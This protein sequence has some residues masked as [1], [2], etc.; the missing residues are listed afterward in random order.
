MTLELPPLP[1]SVPAGQCPPWDLGKVRRRPCPVC[2]RDSPEPIV[3]RPD[4]LVVHKCAECGMI[5]LA[6]VPCQD[7]IDRLYRGYGAFK[8]L[9]PPPESGSRQRRESAARYGHLTSIL[10][11]TGGLRGLSVCEIGCSYG[12][13]LRL[14]RHMGARTHGVEL[15]AEA[16]RFVGDGGISVAERLEGTEQHDVVCMFQV[17]EHLVRPAEMI[18]AVAKAVVADGRVLTAVPNGGEYAKAGPTWIGFRVDLEHLNYFDLQSLSRLLQRHGLLVERF[19][20]H[21]QPSV[22]RSA[23]GGGRPAGAAKRIWRRLGRA[24]G[25]PSAA[26]NFASRGTFVLTALARAPAKKG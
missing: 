4:Q 26:E 16:R 17:L 11:Q 1:S 24:L 9:A 14:V 19:W 15:D 2:D 12:A 7:D 10:E 20:E 21:C 13:F 8:G 18:S 23:H 6:D 22:A 25:G 5:Y 3:K